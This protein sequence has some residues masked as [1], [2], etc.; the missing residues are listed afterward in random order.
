VKLEIFN[1]LGQKIRTLVDD[2]FKPGTYHVLWNGLDDF[3]NRVA[4]GVYLYQLRADNAL[5]T[6]KMLLVK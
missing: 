6:K 3:G 5:I 4:T 1:I 2:N